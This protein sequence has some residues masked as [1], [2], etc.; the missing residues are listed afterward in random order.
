[1]RTSHITAAIVTATFGL[2]LTACGGASDMATK[3]STPAPMSPMPSSMPSTTPMMS[4]MMGTFMGLNG[5]MVAGAASVTGAMVDLSGFSSDEGPDLNLYL[6]KGTTEADVKS[7]T[8]LGAISYNKATQQFML[9]E[10]MSTSS[11]KYLV[12]HCDKA[13][14]VFGAAPLG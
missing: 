5:K 1:M 14:A 7:G 8:K 4:S 6:T 10:G 13:H 2:A 9:P 12:V 3:A 11:Y